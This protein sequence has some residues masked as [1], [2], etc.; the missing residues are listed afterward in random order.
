MARNTK[1]SLPESHYSG[2]IPLPAQ[3]IQE[4]QNQLYVVL[5]T[6]LDARE[7]MEIFRAYA[8]HQVS[9]DCLELITTQ[10]HVRVGSDHSKKHFFRIQLTNTE[11]TSQELIF[12][13]EN[14]F[15]KHEENLLDQLIRPLSFPLRNALKYQEA[16]QSALT[17]RLTNI[18]NRVAMDMALSH[19]VESAQRYGQHLS[20]LMVDLDHFKQVNDEY[21]HVAGDIVLAKIAKLIKETVRNA[22]QVFRYGGEEFLILMVNTDHFGAFIFGERLRGRIA[23]LPIVCQSVEIPVTASIGVATLMEMETGEELITRTD[24]ALYQAKDF[25]RNC[26]QSAVD[27]QKTH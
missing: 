1:I 14:P 12:S 26:V 19:A 3:S 23:G 5:Q 18:G 10:H 16:V 27:Y 7:L 13:R 21:G 4:L 25:G 2:V 11:K 22:D 15:N 6:S 24:H 17:D 20:T 8:Q 9:F